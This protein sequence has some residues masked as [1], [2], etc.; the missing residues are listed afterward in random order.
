MYILCLYYYH[1]I[2]IDSHQR[3]LH[4]ISMKLNISIDKSYLFIEDAFNN[5]IFK[6]NGV[7]EKNPNV[8]S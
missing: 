5:I 6:I 1:L 2:S 3:I 8:C 4:F 7:I